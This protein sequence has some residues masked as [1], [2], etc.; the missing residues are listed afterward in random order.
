MGESTRNIVAKV[1]ETLFREMSSVP[2]SVLEICRWNNKKFT[3]TQIL[4]TL[5]EL[6]LLAVL[7]LPGSSVG[8]PYQSNFP[9]WASETR[10]CVIPSNETFDTTLIT[11]VLQETEV[12]C[13]DR[14]EN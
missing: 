9:G 10:R 14:N 12:P 8:M 13:S 3:R 4:L 1:H 6:D 5:N 11:E 7:T 2:N